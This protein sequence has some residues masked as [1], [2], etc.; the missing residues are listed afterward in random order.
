MCEWFLWKIT[1]NPDFLKNVIFSDEAN[2]YTNGVVNKQQVRHWAQENPH[3]HIDRNQQGA[4]RVMV[5]LGVWDE[6]FIGP[7]FFDGTV[8]GQTYV[9]MLGNEMFPHLHALGG[10]P[11]WFQHDGAAP[12]FAACAREF[13]DEEF[14]DHWIG[15]GGP[16]PLAARSPDLNPLDFA[17]WG[18]LKDRVYRHEIRDVDHL[19][20]RIR[21]ECENFE[22][23]FLRNI[24]SSMERR[25]NLCFNE[26]GR[27]I[28]HLL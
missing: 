25:L 11:D 3:W 4:A 19:K 13:L 10:P 6:S 8:T 28:E 2:F 20:F 22:P 24:I 5:W 14:R 7:F 9:N 26:G 18:L 1:Q 16:V 12:H 17:I 21:E 15:R 27:H 23:R